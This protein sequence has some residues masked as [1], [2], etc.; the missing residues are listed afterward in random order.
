MC[1]ASV[2]KIYSPATS[3]ARFEHV[4]RKVFYLLYKALYNGGVVVVNSEAEG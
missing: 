1:N 4:L 3:T 2:V